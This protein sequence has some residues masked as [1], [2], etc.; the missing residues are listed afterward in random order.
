MKA[1]RRENAEK[2]L[3]RFGAIVAMIVI[4]GLV[5]YAR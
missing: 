3:A 1:V 2:H 5:I 4:W